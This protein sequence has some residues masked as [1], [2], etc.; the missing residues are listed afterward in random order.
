MEPSPGGRSWGCVP[1]LVLYAE[2]DAVQRSKRHCCCDG[3]RNAATVDE[4]KTETEE[5]PAAKSHAA[6]DLS[7]Q[8]KLKMVMLQRAHS[9][10][11]LSPEI[12]NNEKCL[13]WLPSHMSQIVQYLVADVADVAR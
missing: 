12:K 7:L 13:R 8:L 10:L 4:A 5:A 3:A 11:A 6:L 9:S 1:T 2:T